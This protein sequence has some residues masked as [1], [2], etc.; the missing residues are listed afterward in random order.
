MN[1]MPQRPNIPEIPTIVNRVLTPEEQIFVLRTGRVLIEDFYERNCS[2]CLQRNAV[3]E[4][5]AKKLEGYV[6][7]EMV[8]ANETRLGV[9]GI[10]GRIIPIENET[11]SEE[12]LMDIF[13]GVALKQ[14]RECLIREI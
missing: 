7:L 12:E 14:P 8:P 9:I 2:Y 6:V 13:C 5:F 1:V 11:I 10:G 4:E 3:L